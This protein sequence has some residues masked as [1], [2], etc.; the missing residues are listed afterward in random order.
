MAQT[1]IVQGGA[2]EFEDPKNLKLDLSNPRSP[3]AAFDTEDDVIEFLVNHADVEE[4]IQAILNSGWHDYEALIVLGDENVVLE[5][6]RRL[7]AL[8]ILA[9]PELQ[10]RL[11]IEFNETVGHA[12]LPEAVR[13]RRV[14]SRRDAR[15]YIGFKHING[16]FKWDALAKAKYAAEWYEEGGN[17]QQISRRLGDRHNTVVR[18]V[19][20][21]SVLFDPKD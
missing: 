1:V 2:D 16:P 20:A 15:D 17:I 18:L 3:D 11:K 21:F 7:A 6:N 4:L 19:R 5:G 8:R 10:D 13:I 9:D 14:A 12:V